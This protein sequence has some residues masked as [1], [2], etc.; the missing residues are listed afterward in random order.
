M[1]APAGESGWFVRTRAIVGLSSASGS[2]ETLPPGAIGEDQTSD[3]L[4]AYFGAGVGVGRAF[5][6]WG[7]P[8]RAVVD[9][10]LNFRHDTDVDALFPGGVVEY[11]NNLQ[12]IDLRASLL[13][14]VLHFG[15]GRFYVGGGLG[16][17]RVR[18]EVSIANTPVEEV[19]SEWKLSPSVEAGIVFEGF[20]RRVKPEISYRFRW[21]GD[22]ESATFATGERLRYE[23]FHIHDLMFGFTIPLGPEPLATSSVALY[24]PTPSIGS[25]APWTGFHAGAF[26]G[27][28]F[29]E[30]TSVSG[31]ATPGGVPYNVNNS[32]DLGNDDFL[33]GGELGVDWQWSWLV[34][35]LAGE[36]GYLNLGASTG[37]PAAAGGDTVTSFDTD[38]YGGLSARG[39]LAWNNFLAFGRVGVAFINAEATTLDTCTAAPCGGATV[40]ASE[41]DILFAF[42]AGGGLEYLVTPSWS[43]GAEYRYVHFYDELQPAGAA[44]PGGPVA[45]NVMPGDLHLARASLNYRW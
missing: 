25:E 17:A 19:N 24:E 26:G 38:F 27:W 5:S 9:G 29:A 31:L 4:Q 6:A 15:W 37:D 21:V 23:D 41:E 35:G 39:G 3:D 12:T 13:A 16:A 45:Q 36:A 42:T 8:L 20:S 33:A 11:Q 43:V 32:Y 1:F 34:L 44:V 40:S 30:D 14:D 2:F 28:A 10:S 7:I 22:T 18:N